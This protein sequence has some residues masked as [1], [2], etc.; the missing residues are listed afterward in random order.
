MGTRCNLM[1]SILV[2]C[3]A[4]SLAGCGTIYFH[5]DAVQER[6]ARVKE[7]FGKIDLTNKIEGRLETLK[8]DETFTDQM[9]ARRSVAERDLILLSLLR[10]LQS[11]TDEGAPRSS[12]STDFCLDEQ[13]SFADLPERLAARMICRLNATGVHNNWRK[14]FDE[15]PNPKRGTTAKTDTELQFL[16][17]DNRTQLVAA[18]ATDY[19]SPQAPEARRVARESFREIRNAVAGAQ[20]EIAN[21]RSARAEIN[22]YALSA[23]SLGRE[24][25]ADEGLKKVDPDGPLMTEPTCKNIGELVS[26]AEADAE[27]F[28]IPPARWRDFSSALHHVQSSCDK[29]NEADKAF[30]EAVAR[31]VCV[32]AN[33]K[34]P[35]A[36]SLLAT[37]APAKNVKTQPSGLIGDEA[38]CAYQDAMLTDLGDYIECLRNANDSLARAADAVK[39]AQKTVAELLKQKSPPEANKKFL[40]SLEAVAGKTKTANDVALAAGYKK[41]SDVLSALIIA[42]A[43]VVAADE[44][45]SEDPARRPSDL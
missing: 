12:F 26:K 7:E 9:A 5:S 23:I 8:A 34:P 35:C 24:V 22:A 11:R 13:S 43:R 27:T 2:S 37:E 31:L 16:S 30:Q 25:I 36:S 38:T 39:Q 28:D 15:P 45:A 33:G 4:L 20:E 10:P 21:I 29:L 44:D 17:E 18:R 3:V 1:S 6:T 19:L 40:E 42:E 14:D 41:L 32:P